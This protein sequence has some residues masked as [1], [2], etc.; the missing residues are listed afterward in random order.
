MLVIKR[1]IDTKNANKCKPGT[2]IMKYYDETFGEMIKSKDE[3]TNLRQK[4][5]MKL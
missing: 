5:G 3:N 2:F 1:F 4:N